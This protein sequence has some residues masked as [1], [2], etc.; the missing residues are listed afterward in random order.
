MAFRSLGGM[1]SLALSLPCFLSDLRLKSC[2]IRREAEKE[3]TSNRG[4]NP[5]Q[6]SPHPHSSLSG[7]PKL[8]STPYLLY[9]LDP[10]MCSQ[11]CTLYEALCFPGFGP[12]SRPST[13]T[14]SQFRPLTQFRFSHHKKLCSRPIHG[15]WTMIEIIPFPLRFPLTTK[16]PRTRR[17]RKREK[18][19][20]NVP[21]HGDFKKGRNEGTTEEMRG[22][23]IIAY[24]KGQSPTALI[25]RIIKGLSSSGF[26]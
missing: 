11:A 14:I 9:A 16:C 20:L 13:D 18:G 4:G 19:Q 3:V 17:R 5:D 22:F 23:R 1:S 21:V 2:S 10:H 7:N 24:P 26:P 25:Q 8:E 12:A 6:R 15:A